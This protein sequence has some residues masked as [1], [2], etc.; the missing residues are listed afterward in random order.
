[1]MFFF[2]RKQIIID[3]FVVN[4]TIHDYYPIQSANKFFPDGWKKHPRSKKIKLHEYVEPSSNIEVELPTIKKCI[5]FIDLF[6]SGFIIPAWCDFGIEFQENGKMTYHANGNTVIEQHPRWQVWNDLYS[7]YGHAKVISPWIL[8]EKDGVKFS[9]HQCD[10]NNTQYLDRVRIVS[11]VVDYKYQHQT[12][13]NMFI[14][15]GSIV[16]FS[17][18]QPLVHL[19]PISE[20]DVKI[21]THLVTPDEIMKKDYKPSQYM[22]Q[23][24]FA[25]KVI[26]NKE[27]KCPFGFGKK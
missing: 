25:K 27:S 16:N 17:A 15:K 23:Y 10:W 12:N 1:M 22:N 7:D 9:W 4:P 21:K 13:I 6:S 3:C 24:N 26:D 8:H 18:N 19:I 5:G 20:R 11:G 2:K 14:K